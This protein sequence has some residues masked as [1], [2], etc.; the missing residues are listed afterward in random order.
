MF[1]AVLTGHH[2]TAVE[3]RHQFAQLILPL[4]AGFQR[5]G[6]HDGFEKIQLCA[7]TFGVQLHE[8][9]SFLAEWE[10]LFIIIACAAEDVNTPYRAEMMRLRSSGHSTAVTAILMASPGRKGS[11]PAHSR[12]ETL[13]PLPI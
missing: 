4:A 12:A 2:V 13:M 3:R 7:D 10:R 1:E 8:H 6:G 11:M 9:G 5:A